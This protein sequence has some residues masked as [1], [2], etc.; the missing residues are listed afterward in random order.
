MAYGA[1]QARIASARYTGV[2]RGRF[3]PFGIPQ[4]MWHAPCIGLGCD[5]HPRQTI[6]GMRLARVGDAA[7]SRREV[8]PA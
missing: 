6:G 3:A 7:A 2:L 1:F 4:V 8:N 5:T